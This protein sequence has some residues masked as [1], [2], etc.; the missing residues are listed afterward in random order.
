VPSRC[1][2]VRRSLQM[3]TKLVNT[4]AT[5]ATRTGRVQHGVGHKTPFSGRC[6]RNAA[7]DPRL[8]ILQLDTEGLMQIRSLSLRN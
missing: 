5:T 1:P 7:E 2:P 4:R 6:S 3:S 8:N